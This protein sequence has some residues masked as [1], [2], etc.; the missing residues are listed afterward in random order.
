MTSNEFQI[1]CFGGRLNCKTTGGAM[2][3][4]SLNSMMRDHPIVVRSRNPN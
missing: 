2:M 3:T 1:D 4:F